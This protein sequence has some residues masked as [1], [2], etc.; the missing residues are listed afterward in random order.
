VSRR[1]L[2]ASKRGGGVRIGIFGGS[3][4]P[5]H[6][7]HL[8]LARAAASE[9]D[10]DQVIFVPSFQNPLKKK[11]ALLPSA[12]RTKLLRAAINNHPGFSVSLCEIKRKSP[13]F[14]VDTLKY[15]KRRFGKRAVLYFLSGA[16]ALKTLGRWRSVDQIFRLCRFVAM[17]RPGY[18]MKKSSKPILQVPFA[19]LPLS[20]SEV[21]SRLRRRQPL[22]GLVPQGTERLLKNYFKKYNQEA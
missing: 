17:T 14:T 11:E 20:S 13:S 19:A 2:V 21:R 7:G 3:F 5:V 8:C 1:R 15:F 12:L 18:A 16:D 10:L 4:N 6:Q 9:L 22:T